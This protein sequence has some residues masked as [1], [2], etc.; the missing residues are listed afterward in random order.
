MLVDDDPLVRTGLGLILGGQ[1]DI[2]VV[3]EATNG[4]KA[5]LDRPA[6]LR[7]DI[8]LM[9]IRMPV[10][11]GLAATEALVKRPGAPRSSCSPRSAPMILCCVRCRAG[12]AGSCSKTPVKMVEAIHAV[13]DGDPILS[14]SV[15]AIA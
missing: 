3:G 9:D 8:V 7:P 13:A 15:T 2:T 4:K 5:L 10:M 1:P 6:G 14:P 11:D 12:R